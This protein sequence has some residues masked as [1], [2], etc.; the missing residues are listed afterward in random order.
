MANGLNLLIKVIQSNVN[1]K[2]N[3]S[4]QPTVPAGQE[5]S[6]IG[7]PAQPATQTVEK[8]SAK[9]R[10]VELNIESMRC[11]LHPL[12]V[13]RPVTIQ[14]VPPG[15][16]TPIQI[17]ADQCPKEGCG[18]HYIP[19]Y[20]YFP[21]VSGVHFDLTDKTGKIPCSVHESSGPSR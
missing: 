21:L 6:K 10:P 18:R 9:S 19:E 4:L 20:G 16:D 13:L 3:R 14:I 8:D 7:S 17:K 11:D 15:S 5:L 1:R 12:Y 2:G